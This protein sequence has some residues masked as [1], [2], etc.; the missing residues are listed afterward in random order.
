MSQDYNNVDSSLGC[1]V[2]VID[3]VLMGCTKAC[4]R[5]LCH[6]TVPFMNGGF[7]SISSLLPLSSSLVPNDKFDLRSHL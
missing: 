2:I 4:I 6:R 3:L 7:V 5:P 1:A